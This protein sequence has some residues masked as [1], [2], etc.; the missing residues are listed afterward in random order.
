MA[1][2]ISRTSARPTRSAKPAAAPA[3]YR[4]LKI[5]LFY[6]LLLVIALVFLSP[7]LLTLSASFKSLAQINSQKAWTLPSSLGIGNFRTLF[8]Q[9]DFG[10]YLLNTVIVTVILTLGQVT[11]SVMGAYAFARLQF[12]G[13]NALFA[14][15]LGTLMVPNVVTM[16]PLYVIMDKAGLL[17]TYWA[18]FL[19]YTLGTPYTVFLMRQFM[20]TLPS[21]MFE[22]ARLDGCSEFKILYRIVV[23]VARPIIITATI[24]ALVFSWNNFLWPL[25]ATNS[26]DLQVLT[27]GIANLSSNFGQQWNLVL[28]GSL[29]ALIPMVAIFV[30]FQRY[31]VNSI[32][33]TGVN[34]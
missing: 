8:S 31:I 11:F 27:V 28:A 16:I 22:A 19:P 20:M 12:P 21:E 14:M 17:D 4:G 7:Y 3:P 2:T 25:I 15:Y 24:I 5:G 10:E 6:L 26:N 30:A 23:P 29:V 18:I 32:Q 34:R 33:L 9:Y 1:T 13:R